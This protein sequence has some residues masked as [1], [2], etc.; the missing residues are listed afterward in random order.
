MDDMLG[1]TNDNIVAKALEKALR[2]LRDGKPNDKSEKD[3]RYAVTITE[4]EKVLSYFDFYVIR[5]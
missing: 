2:D 1:T 5:D 4:M 3:R